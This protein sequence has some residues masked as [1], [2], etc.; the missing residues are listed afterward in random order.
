MS[1][2]TPTPTPG[3]PLAGYYTTPP[4]PGAGGTPAPSAFGTPVAA[5]WV[6]AGWWRRVG[7]T[8]STAS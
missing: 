5:H 4:P 8:L 2:P 3:D 1:D 6:L 7:A